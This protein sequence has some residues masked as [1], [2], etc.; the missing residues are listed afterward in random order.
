MQSGVDIAKDGARHLEEWE[1]EEDGHNFDYHADEHDEEISIGASDD[2]PAGEFG[3]AKEEA[4]HGVEEEH[5]EEEVLPLFEPLF[6][7]G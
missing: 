2:G 3:G 7:V 1:G 4:K 6:G 5:L